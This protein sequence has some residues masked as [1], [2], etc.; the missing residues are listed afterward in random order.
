ME[1]RQIE[2]GSRRNAKPFYISLFA[3]MVVISGSHLLIKISV[4][5]EIVA[6]DT[7]CGKR[8]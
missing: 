5:G 3:Q 2:F 8:H 6:R 7:N 1:P 4:F